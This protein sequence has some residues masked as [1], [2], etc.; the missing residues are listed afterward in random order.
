MTSEI[1]IM[2]NDVIALAADSAIT[3]DSEKTYNGVNKIFML[4]ND[5]P[6]GIM[7]FGLAKFENISMETLIKEHSKKTDFKK[8]KNIINIKKDFLE[9]LSKVTNTTK[10]DEFLDYHL[11]NFKEELIHQKNMYGEKEFYKF[12]KR[13]SNVEIFESLKNAFESEKYTKKFEK[14][15]KKYEESEINLNNLKKC[16]CS[17]ITNISTGIVIAGFNKEDMFPSCVAFNIIGNINDEI[18]YYDMDTKLNYSEPLILPFAQTDVINAYLTGIDGNSEDQIKQEFER[19]IETY[20]SNIYHV[21]STK[22]IDE[23]NGIKKILI[24]TFNDNINILKKDFYSPILKTVDS[25]PK[26]ELGNLASTLIEITSLK[27]K[28]DS[29]LESVGGNIDV[30]LISKGDGF[31]WKKRSPYFNPKLNPQFF[32]EK[33]N[34]N[35]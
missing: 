25:L 31:I 22:D 33:M 5:P 17:Y 32:D 30:A 12:I 8:L 18:L 28:I 35:F 6:M 16:F 27:R 21:K 26:E 15:I 4:S 9:Y 29:N 2:N 14:L 1:M 19:L 13:F 7:I 20:T 11:E 3:V 10:I 34:K 24:N 23:I